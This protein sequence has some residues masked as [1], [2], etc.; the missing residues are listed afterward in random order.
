MLKNKIILALLI[1][2]E[3][4]GLHA[5]EL[6]PAFYGGFQSGYGSTTWRGLV[7]PDV[8]QNE[9]ILISTPKATNEGGIAYGF[10]GGYEFSTHFAVEGFYL[11]YPKADIY[12]IKDSIFA[13]E[14][15]RCSFNSFSTAIG[16]LAKLMLPLPNTP[17]RLFSTVGFAHNQRKDE[18]YEEALF[19]PSFGAGIVFN[20]TTHLMA[21]LGFN[22]IAGY[23]ESEL[24]PINSFIPFLYSGTLG[25]AYRF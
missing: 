7:P 3:T 1:L 10:F 18:I 24:S 2:F 9:A 15:D 23:G 6:Q 11:R 8:K 19:S 12:F 14:H 20:M 21:Q 13:Y 16:L 17:F 4:S 22:Y 25:F 5:I